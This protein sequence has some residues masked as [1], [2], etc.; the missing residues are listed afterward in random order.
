M[1]ILEV[2]DLTV[3]IQ[4]KVILKNLSFTLKKG[5]SHILFGPNGSG[6]TTLIGALLGLPSYEIT[7]GKIFFM[8]QDIT[9]KST[10][11]RAKLGIVASFQS[12]PE[13]AGVKLADLLKLCLGKKPEDSFSS[14]EQQLIERF[15][16]TAFLG[17]DMN[18]GFSGGE[19]KRSE[20]L[21][22]IF[23]KGKL[24]L[25]DEPDS[26]VDVESLKLLASELQR[27]IERT[28]SAALL[29][30]H[31]GDIMDYIKAKYGCVL[32]NGNFHCFTDPLRMYED[33]KNYGYEECVACRRRN[34]GGWNFEQ[35]K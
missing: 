5:E 4:G 30:T 8:G 20:I 3:S 23:L 10:D 16:L 19:R 26:G 14:E 25:L 15:K 29:I 7:S 31:K 17:R 22:L 9:A 27:Y 6:K 28:G 2:K 24:L 12:P 18:V 11:E 13:I 35:R 34:T 32:L 1:D 21:Q 33:I